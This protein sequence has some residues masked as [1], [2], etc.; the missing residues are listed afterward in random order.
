MFCSECGTGGSGGIAPSGAIDGLLNLLRKVKWEV[1]VEGGE[2]LILGLFGPLIYYAF[3]L[4]GLACSI[5]V[6]A[7][8]G[9]FAP[10][11]YG[12]AWLIAAILAEYMG[13]KLIPAVIG[14]VRKT[15]TVFASPALLN[16]VI[17]LMLLLG[18]AV[19]VC[20][21][22]GTVELGRTA[23]V[24][25][26]VVG[27]VVIQI[28]ARMAI[29][30]ELLSATVGGDDAV[31]AGEELLGIAEFF[32]KM[33]ART[34]TFLWVLAPLALIPL[35]FIHICDGRYI[36]YEYFKGDFFGALTIGLIPLLVY[37]FMLT[38]M[39]LIELVRAVVRGTSQLDTLIELKRGEKK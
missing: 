3:G 1:C 16:C 18:L 11:W 21:I 34:A 20:G 37:G 38:A 26:G 4:S 10:V 7:K 28:G 8:I 27:C 30:P 39:L 23:P 31:S 13:G 25:W 35:M 2:R 17:V 5:V 9:R 32:V 15:R 33:A 6:A 22:I 36:A 14:R 19:L 29:K 24:L 12:I